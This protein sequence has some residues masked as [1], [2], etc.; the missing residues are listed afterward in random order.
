MP[1]L[2]GFKTGGRIL[3]KENPVPANLQRDEEILVVPPFFRGQKPPSSFPFRG[4]NA[5]APGCLPV[6]RISSAGRLQPFSVLKPKTEET[7]LSA[8]GK[9]STGSVH[10]PCISDP[11]VGHAYLHG[12]FI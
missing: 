7:P 10:S 4:E 12:K 5:G 9:S 3:E 11:M 8:A 2:S 1:D 6:S